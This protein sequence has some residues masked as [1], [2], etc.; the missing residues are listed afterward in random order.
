MLIDVEF[1]ACL[2]SCKSQ[3]YTFDDGKTATGY[4]VGNAY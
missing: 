3:D 2:M 1:K 4:R